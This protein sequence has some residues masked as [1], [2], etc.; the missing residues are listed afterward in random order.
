MKKG[1]KTI[2]VSA[3]VVSLAILIG[4]GITLIS[5]PPSSWAR[6]FHPGFQRTGFPSKHHG[7]EMAEFILWKMDRH[8]KSLDLSE[9]QEVRYK[10]MREQLKTSLTGLIEGRRTLHEMMRREMDKENPNIEAL[11]NLIKGRLENMRVDISTNLDLFVTFYGLLDADQKSRVA[12]G[13]GE[14]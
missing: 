13:A 8:A 11:A 9:A 7:E 6:G 14:S 12:R 5:G 4:L 10:E 3:A 1:R 2:L